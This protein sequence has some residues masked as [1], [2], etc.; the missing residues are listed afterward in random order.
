MVW[1]GRDRSEEDTRMR[2]APSSVAGGE[3]VDAGQRLALEQLKGG[4]ATGGDVA[5]L[6]LLASVGD[7]GG[8]VAEA[9]RVAR[10]RST[11]LDSDR[12]RMALT[13]HRR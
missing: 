10:G 7:E 12:S 8:G 4:S 11:V 5:E 3:R 2:A 9:G 13:R 1:A 6:V